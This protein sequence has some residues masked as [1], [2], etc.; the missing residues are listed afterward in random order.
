MIVGLGTDITDIE[1]LTTI[2]NR[3][4]LSFLQK[5]LTPA[6]LEI[7][8][9]SH[10]I[11]Y[12]AGRFAAKEATVKALGTG[13]SHGIGLRHIEVLNNDSGAPC[14]ALKESALKQA[15]ALGAKKY[16]VSISHERRYAVATVILEG[17]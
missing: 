16:L 9:G 14:L 7:G 6:E 17:D 5:I 1:R 4:G 3:Y 15:K 10:L 12:A 13:F 11:S 8:G 2:Y